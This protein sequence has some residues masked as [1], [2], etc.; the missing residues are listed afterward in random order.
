MNTKKKINR[1]KKKRHKKGKTEPRIMIQARL[2]HVFQTIRSTSCAL[3]HSGSPA[4]RP[5]MCDPQ[6]LCRPLRPLCAPASTCFNI[7]VATIVCSLLLFFSC[8][9]HFPRPYSHSFSFSNSTGANQNAD[10]DNTGQLLC[11]FDQTHQ[12]YRSVSNQASWLL[13]IRSW[14]WPRSGSG[15]VWWPRSGRVSAW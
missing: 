4:P 1:T 14:V 10:S 15:S 8:D 5:P 9:R 6:P 12:S 11:R 3:I 2:K 13:S 7:P